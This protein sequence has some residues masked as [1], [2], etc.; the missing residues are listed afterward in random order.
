MS[1]PSPRHARL[2][3]HASWANALLAAAL[4]EEPVGDRARRILAHLY[5]TEWLWLRR[6]GVEVTEAPVWPD[7]TAH[8]SG[9]QARALDAAWSAFLDGLD[10][11]GMRRTIEYVNSRGEPHQSVVEDVLD[12]VLLHAA[13][14]RG[15]L[16]LLLRDAGREPPVVDLAHAARTGLLDD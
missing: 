13:H 7:W 1:Q 6:L 11:A 10:A 15:Q 16:V 8:D 2:F 5:A 4:C 14:H 12:H 3:R 9:G